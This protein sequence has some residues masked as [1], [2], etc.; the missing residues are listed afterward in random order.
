MQC[1]VIF[2]A[3]FSRLT[4]RVEVAE[5][6]GHIAAADQDFQTASTYVDPCQARSILRTLS[7]HSGV[8]IF[9]LDV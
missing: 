1:P 4:C 2:P 6:L 5:V 8:T 9:L 3:I 7:C